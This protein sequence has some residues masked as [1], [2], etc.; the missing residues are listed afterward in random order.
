MSYTKQ[1]SL[2]ADSDLYKKV[3]FMKKVSISL[4]TGLQDNFKSLDHY[5]VA[6]ILRIDNKMSCDW[7]ARRMA[8]ERMQQST[9]S[10]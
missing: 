5:I 2:S 8:G 9:Y 3:S 10:T 6:A 4:V 7:L 1:K